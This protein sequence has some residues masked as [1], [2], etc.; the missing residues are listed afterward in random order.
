M[1]Y[2]AAVRGVLVCPIVGVRSIMKPD[3]I[4]Q[5]D[6]KEIRKY[7]DHKALLLG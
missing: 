3:F 5:D 2:L 7:I 6:I 1:L 4:C